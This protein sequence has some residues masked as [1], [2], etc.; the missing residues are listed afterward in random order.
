VLIF[1]LTEAVKKVLGAKTLDYRHFPKRSSRFCFP[2][3]SLC[4]FNAEA[5]SCTSKTLAPSPCSNWLISNGFQI[6]KSVL[7]KNR[8]T[9]T[10]L[11]D[12]CSLFHD[13]DPKSQGN[14]SFGYRLRI[15]NKRAVGGLKKCFENGCLLCC[16]NM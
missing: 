11:V 2:Y 15:G 7:R 14:G 6:M 5:S 8:L 16:C 4:S 13:T 1:C 3:F 9:A 10:L 12:R